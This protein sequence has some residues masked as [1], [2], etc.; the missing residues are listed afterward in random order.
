[1]WQRLSGA[2][3]YYIQMIRVAAVSQVQYGHMLPL[4]SRPQ[5]LNFTPGRLIA[6]TN[7]PEVYKL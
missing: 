1:M 3:Q 2:F 4:E 6:G 7:K 5:L